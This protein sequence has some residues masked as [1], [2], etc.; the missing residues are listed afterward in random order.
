MR[1]LYVYQWVVEGSAIYGFCLDEK[2]TTCL[3]RIH[4]FKPYLYIAKKIVKLQKG[5]TDREQL[6]S[7]GSGVVKHVVFKKKLLRS[8]IEMQFVKCY[9]GRESHRSAF[10]YN[11]RNKRIKTYE[12]E[13]CV[14]DQFLSSAE[15]PTVGWV[16]IE[17]SAVEE[18]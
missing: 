17:A 15:I 16:E 10:A 12:S 6:Q 13:I 18:K 2:S 5:D 14:L 7:I 8:P 9:F 1:L 11:A 3:V 4:D